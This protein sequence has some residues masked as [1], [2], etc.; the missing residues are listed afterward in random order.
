M[1]RFIITIC[2]LFGFVAPVMADGY[3]FMT[4]GGP[5]W[6]GLVSDIIPSVDDTYDLGSATY[7]WQDLYIDGTAYIDALAAGSISVTP[8]DNPAVYFDP[9][10]ASESEWWIG[11]NHDAGEDDNDPWEIRQSATPGTNVRWQV[12]TSGNTTVTGSINSVNYRTIRIDAAAMVPC[13]TNGAEAGTY[14]YGTNDI[15]VDYYA[16]D[17]G[18]T[19]ER[20]QTKL[21]MPEDW[22]RSTVK[23]KFYWANASG[24]SAS[25]TVEWGIKAGALSNDDAIDAA[26][27]D[28]VTISDTLI[29]DGDLHVTSATGALTVGGTP[30]LGDLIVFEIYRNTD[31]TDDMAEDA[32]LL[33]AVIQYVT[34]NTA[35]SA[36]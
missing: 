3:V 34:S 18:A 4:R 28:P 6:T 30:A 33:Y 15:D 2:I 21:V 19:E 10:T 25:D 17:D 9:D 23:V 22:D 7:E 13:T 5:N 1:K 14:E 12:D 16:F 8:T 29:A 31:G 27:G 32:W 20:V 35:V 11:T 26:L 36:W 24:A